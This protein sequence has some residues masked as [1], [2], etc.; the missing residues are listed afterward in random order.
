MA[1]STIILSDSSKNL[2]ALV[3]GFF[4]SDLNEPTCVL[5]L[6]KLKETPAHIRVDSLWWLI[7]EKMGLRLWWDNGQLL[8]PMESRNSMRFDYPLSSREL[9]SGKWSRKLYLTCHSVESGITKQKYFTFGL[10][11]EKQGQ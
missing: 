5:D 1:F 10:D 11:A 9:T 2:K 6:D 7:E 8:I 3:R 4:T